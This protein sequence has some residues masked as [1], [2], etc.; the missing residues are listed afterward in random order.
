MSYEIKTAGI[1]AVLVFFD[2]I[3]IRLNYALEIHGA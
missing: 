2:R 1:P 3:P